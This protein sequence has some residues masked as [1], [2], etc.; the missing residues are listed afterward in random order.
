[1]L[2]IGSYGFLRFVL[3]IVPEGVIYYYP[4][5]SI[6]CIL[7]IIFS[8]ICAMTQVDLKKIIAYSSIAHMN[9]IVLALLTADLTA[10]N[11]SL[12]YMLAHGFSSAALFYCIGL[13]YDRFNTKDT[14]RSNQVI[15]ALPVVG[16]FFFLFNLINISFPLSYSFICEI[17]VLVAL[18]KINL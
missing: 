17:S 8:S 4:F 18:V 16:I 7:S 15:N 10:I 12:G 5:A 6:F 2:K 1:M 11:A 9:Y 3:P 14:T 13:F